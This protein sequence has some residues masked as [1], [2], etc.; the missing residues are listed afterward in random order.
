MTEHSRRPRR[1]R[2][3]ATRTSIALGPEEKLVLDWWI[4]EKGAASMSKGIRLLLE[5]AEGDQWQNLLELARDSTM[6]CERHNEP[7]LLYNPDTEQPLCRICTISFDSAE[8]VNL[9]RYCRRHLI[10][11]FRYC[12]MCEIDKTRRAVPVKSVSA[13]TAIKLETSGAILIDVRHTKHVKGTFTGARE[14]IYKEFIDARSG[15]LIEFLDTLGPDCT[16]I[17]FDDNGEGRSYG[18]AGELVLRFGME[19]RVSVVKGGITALKSASSGR[20]EGVV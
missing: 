6:V 1:P 16:L 5:N 18:A 3:T 10:G 19:N 7:L 20:F 13:A 14:L 12:A 8:Q 9:M 17:L 2:K 15:A 11:Y 4:G